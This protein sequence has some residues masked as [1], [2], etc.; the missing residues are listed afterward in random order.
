MGDAERAAP[1]ALGMR[2]RAD[3]AAS[4]VT[5]G[6]DRLRLRSG[7]LGN[8]AA[9]GTACLCFRAILAVGAQRV[10]VREHGAP[11]PRAARGVPAERSAAPAEPAP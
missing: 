6:G 4:A 10:G 5:L 3:G 2:Q 1:P 9:P 11:A 7:A 8:L